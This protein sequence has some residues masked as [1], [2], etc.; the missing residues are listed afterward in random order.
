MTAALAS[1]LRGAMEGETV[2]VLDCAALPGP[3]GQFEIVGAR[4]VGFGAVDAGFLASVQPGFVIV[5]LFAAAFD[6]MM[7]VERLEALGYAG[8][9]AVVAPAL[10]KPALVEAELRGLG[11][12]ARLVLICP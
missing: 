4:R 8:R 1:F 3:E 5:P 11:P 9:I 12:G 6:A 10:P 7:V 2:V